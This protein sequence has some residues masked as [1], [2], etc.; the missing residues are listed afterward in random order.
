MVPNNSKGQRQNKKALSNTKHTRLA[1][2]QNRPYNLDGLEIFFEK[3]QEGQCNVAQVEYKE[4]L[5]IGFA[6]KPYPSAITKFQT[7]Y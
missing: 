6:Q 1:N 3:K 2:K 4:K 7:L 5:P